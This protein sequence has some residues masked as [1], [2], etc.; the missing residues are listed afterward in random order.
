MIGSSIGI[1]VAYGVGTVLGAL[2][3]YAARRRSEVEVIEYTI[4]MM[5]QNKFIKTKLNSNSEVVLVE[6]DSIE[7]ED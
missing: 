7:E 6:Y 1:I 2:M 5:I 4:D 3:M